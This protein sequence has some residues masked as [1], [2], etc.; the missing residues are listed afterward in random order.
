MERLWAPWRLVYLEKKEPNT[1]QGGTGCIF[2]D[3]PSPFG[4][5]DTEQRQL[6]DGER[7]IVRAREHAFVIMNRYPYS[8]GHVMV[9]PRAHVSDLAALSPEAFAGLHALLKDTITAVRNAYHPEG[10]NVGM[11]L[12]QAAGAGIADHL[13]YHVVPRWVGDTNFMPVVGDTR[14]ISESLQAAYQRLKSVLAP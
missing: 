4:V 8:N 12:G 10:L 3:Y 5:P 7:L 1:V 6:Q 11:N 14:V 2:C 13:H 9:V